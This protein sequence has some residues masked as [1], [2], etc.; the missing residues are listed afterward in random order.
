[1]IIISP[2]YKIIHYSNNRLENIK[3]SHALSFPE[4]TPEF[5]E[6]FK[7]D[8]SKFK[9]DCDNYHAKYNK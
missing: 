8:Y 5:C 3:L 9:I 6:K 7:E 1:M 4:I 2:D